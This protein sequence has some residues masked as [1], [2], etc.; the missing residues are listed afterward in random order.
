MTEFGGTEEIPVSPNASD[1]EHSDPQQVD[2]AFPGGTASSE[3]EDGYSD[4]P[5]DPDATMRM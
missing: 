1:K 3:D 2:G 4:Y 5:D